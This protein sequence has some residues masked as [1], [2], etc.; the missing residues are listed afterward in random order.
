MVTSQNAGP[1]RFIRNFSYCSD[2]RKVVRLSETLLYLDKK[3]EQ[4]ITEILNGS[5]ISVDRLFA[6]IEKGMN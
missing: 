4:S 5:G 1:A 6:C 3:G 2:N